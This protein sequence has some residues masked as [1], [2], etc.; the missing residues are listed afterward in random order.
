V[1]GEDD[2][3]ALRNAQAIQCDPSLRQM[4]HFFQ[5]QP[6]IDHHPRADDG[7]AVGMQDATRDEMEFESAL[8]RLHGVPGVGPAV[9]ADD[10]IGLRCQRVGQ[11][12]FPFVA[13]LATQD[14]RGG[15]RASSPVSC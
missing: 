2:V 4:V 14:N 7:I 15:H 11:L 10:Q 13:P 3:G 1:V 12:S 9:G 8:L 6:R 5:D